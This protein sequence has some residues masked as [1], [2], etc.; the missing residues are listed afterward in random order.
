MRVI[1]YLRE[2]TRLP[3]GA[4]GVANERAFVVNIVQPAPGEQGNSEQQISGR[5]DGRIVR[6]DLSDD[7]SEVVYQ[8]PWGRVV[9]PFNAFAWILELQAECG[10]CKE[11]RPHV[12]TRKEK[13][14]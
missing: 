1:G 4:D 13:A 14:R 9:M 12:C 11:G 6:G 3:S 5:E 2:K 7:R 8:S 10:Q